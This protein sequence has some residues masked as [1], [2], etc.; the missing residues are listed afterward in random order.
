MKIK[1][2]A[3]NLNMEDEKKIIIKHA[4]IHSNM[5]DEAAINQIKEICKI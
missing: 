4:V 2:A 5:E 3:F 1:D